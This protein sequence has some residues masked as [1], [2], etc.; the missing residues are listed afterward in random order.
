M[1]V[2]VLAL[3]IER[4]FFSKTVRTFVTNKPARSRTWHAVNSMGADVQ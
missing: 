2:A 3:H 1:P 4:R